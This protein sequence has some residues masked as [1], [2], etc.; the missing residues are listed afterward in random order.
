MTP[1]PF[2]SIDAFLVSPVWNACPTGVL[3]VILADHPICLP[4]ML[5]DLD[6]SGVA[7]SIV[8]AHCADT[9]LRRGPWIALGSDPDAATTALNRL[10]DAFDGRWVLSLRAGSFFRFPFCETRRIG[11]LTAFLEAEQRRVL[12]AYELDLYTTDDLD[13][14]ADPR[15]GRWSTDR[16]G[17]FAF[18]HGD[19]RLDLHG[20]LSWRFL[21]AFGEYPDQLAHP[22]LFRAERGV[23]LDRDGRFRDERY[24][25]ISCPWHRSPTGAVM[26][27]RRLYHLACRSDFESVRQRLLWRGSMSVDWASQQLLE[28]G[29]MEPGQWF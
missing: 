12:F 21:E 29:M 5:D 10:I 28:E 17:H 20:G 2:P 4:P 9:A 8:L 23:H 15:H 25:R 14:Q 11:D 26:S 13:W 3:G 7:R 19:G 22:V 1:Q 16:L 18:D 27:L 6:R 24:T